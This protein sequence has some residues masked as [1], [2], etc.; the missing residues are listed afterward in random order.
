MDGVQGQAAGAG[1]CDV[2]VST[3]HEAYHLAEELRRRDGHKRQVLPHGNDWRV[4][5]DGATPFGLCRNG[6]S[7][8]D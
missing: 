2:I 6:M 8:A 7:C 4:T 1:F 3:M 5:L